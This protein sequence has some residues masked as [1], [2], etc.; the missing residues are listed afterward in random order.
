MDEIYLSF[1][2]PY[3]GDFDYFMGNEEWV[4]AVFVFSIAAVLVHFWPQTREGSV[5]RTFVRALILLFFLGEAAQRLGLYGV[6]KVFPAQLGLSLPALFL[7]VLVPSF[8]A[9]GRPARV[10]G[11]TGWALILV[12]TTWLVLDRGVP[13]KAVN[14]AEPVHRRAAAAGVGHAA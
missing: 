1:A 3:C 13:A 11:R 5:L 8:I 4:R 6:L 7:F 12:G 14:D 9:A 10:F 2:S